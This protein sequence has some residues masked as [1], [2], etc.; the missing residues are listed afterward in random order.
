[1]AEGENKMAKFEIW[2]AGHSPNYSCSRPSHTVEADMFD[3]KDGVII[4]QTSGLQNVHAVVLSP[5][6]VVQKV[7]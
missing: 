7:E 3:I 2:A 1:M 6:V 4:F 5:G